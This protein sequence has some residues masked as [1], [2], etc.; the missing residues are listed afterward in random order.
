MPPPDQ[1]HVPRTGGPH[2]AVLGAN[3]GANDGIISTASLVAGVA[4]AGSAHGEVLLA[5]I[6][7]AVA[8]ALSMAAGEHVSVSSQSGCENADLARE[9]AHLEAA[10]EQERQELADI[11]VARGVA[12]RLAREVTRQ[13]MAHDALEAHARDE[14]RITELTQARPLQAGGREGA[15]NMLSPARENTRRS[16]P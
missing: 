14:L 7:G 13:I 2:A 3:D 4:S 10:F 11:H 5:G 8:G 15:G 16:Q 9:K 1:H 12:P 6:A